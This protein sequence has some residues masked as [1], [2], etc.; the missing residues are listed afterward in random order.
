MP[1]VFR[2]PSFLDV[3]SK[4]L[5]EVHAVE[6]LLHSDVFRPYISEHSYNEQSS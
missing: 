4:S 2:M 3:R 5:L 1:C 6:C